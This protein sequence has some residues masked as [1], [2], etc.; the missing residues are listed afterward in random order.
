MPDIRDIDADYQAAYVYEYEGLVRAG[1]TEQATAVAEVLRTRYKHE[2]DEA[3]KKRP[4]QRKAPE[5]ADV[6][7]PAENTAEPKPA[8]TKEVRDA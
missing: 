8:H 1:N 5:R 7:K 2:V 6:A 3:P 4:A